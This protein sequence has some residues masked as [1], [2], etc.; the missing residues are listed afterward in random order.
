MFCYVMFPLATTTQFSHHGGFVKHSKQSRRRWFHA[1]T[2]QHRRCAL[3][4]GT[5]KS[6]NCF[7]FRTRM[8]RRQDTKRLGHDCNVSKNAALQLSNG[9]SVNRGAFDPPCGRM[10]SW[11]ELA[12]MVVLSQ[13]RA[14]D[15]RVVL[16]FLNRKETN[17][18]RTLIQLHKTS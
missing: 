5:F 4:S 6:P 1:T 10:P 17:S 11:L 3:P 16:K 13:N 9:R 18:I 15:V 2:N 8:D 14:H 12:L 7:P